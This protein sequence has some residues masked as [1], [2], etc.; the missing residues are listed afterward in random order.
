MPCPPWP[1]NP[2]PAKYFGKGHIYWFPFGADA[3]NRPGMIVSRER[4]GSNDVTIAM[5][6]DAQNV[7]RNGKITYPYQALADMVNCPGL[8]CDSVVKLDRIFTVRRRRLCHEWYI[9]LAPDTVLARVDLALFYALDLQPFVGDLVM[10]VV[11]QYMLRYQQGFE[12]R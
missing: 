10:D 4:L 8:E 1:A 3:G 9:G 11:N 5:M 12:K 7:L 2:T 6:T